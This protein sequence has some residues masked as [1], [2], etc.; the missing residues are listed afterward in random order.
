MC[1]QEQGAQ[2]GVAELEWRHRALS[3]EIGQ[4]K[5]RGEPVDELLEQARSTSAQITALSRGGETAAQDPGPATSETTTEVLTSAGAVVALRD[6]WRELLGRCPPGSFYLTWEWMASWYETYADEGAV[7]CLTVRDGSGRLLG[8]VPLFLS[9]RRDS[10]LSRRQIGFASTYG[11]SWGSSLELSSPPEAQATV[12]AAAAGYLQTIRPEW[13]CV[14]LL[15][16]PGDAQSVWPLI[17]ALV[18]EDW[19]VSVRPYMRCSLMALPDDPGQVLANLASAK[20]RKH[21]RSG[22]RRLQADY[23]HREWL[24]CADAEQLGLQL[25]R[26]MALNVERRADRARTSTF[27]QTKHR[28]CFQR[29][30]QRFWEAGWLRLLRLRIEGEAVAFQPYLVYRQNVYLLTPAWAPSYAHY[31][32][33]H[34]LF[35]QAL[36]LAIQEGARH[37]D[38]LIGEERYKTRY[39]RATRQL[40]DIVVWP[41][42]RQMARSLVGELWE[43]AVDHAARLARRRY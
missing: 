29:A 12:A 8:V 11:P 27:A 28:L 19:R 6:E 33:G 20:L 34:Q 16:V 42:G 43:R 17:R 5:A 23:P 4:R 18:A 39:T 7:R 31:E 30:M 10:K 1:E 13:D 38:F 41:D 2:E 22:V 14:K 3:R 21:C 15:R 35:V 40:L 32:V 25:E 36:S 37:A 9:R 26:Y 24:L